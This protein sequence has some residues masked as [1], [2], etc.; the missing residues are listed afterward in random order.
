MLTNISYMLT[1]V[2]TF[3]NPGIFIKSITYYNPLK[4]LSKGYHKA[5]KVPKLL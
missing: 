4:T 2:Y 5:C 3:V 1:N